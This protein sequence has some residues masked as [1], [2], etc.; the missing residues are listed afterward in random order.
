MA[1]IIQLSLGLDEPV[2]E[3]DERFEI[4]KEKVSLTAPGGV[5]AFK[6]YLAFLNADDGMGTRTTWLYSPESDEELDSADTIYLNMFQ[7]F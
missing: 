3:V 4:N 2:T 1:T 5:K 7:S 6:R